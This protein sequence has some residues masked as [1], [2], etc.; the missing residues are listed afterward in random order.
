VT[1]TQS[2][3]RI[4]IWWFVYRHRPWLRWAY[5]LGRWLHGARR[6]KNQGLEGTRGALNVEGIDIEWGGACP[7]QGEGTVDGY[8]CYYRSRGECWEI[9]VFPIGTD[10]EKT[11]WPDS[12]WYYDECPYIWPDGGWVPAQVSE[13]CIRKAVQL[14]REKDRPRDSYG[15]AFTR[16]I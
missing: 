11:P 12:V 8:P 6:V 16:N 2:I 4:K 7:V 5:V 10:L 14:F 13:Q 3:S 15:P 9:E 1:K